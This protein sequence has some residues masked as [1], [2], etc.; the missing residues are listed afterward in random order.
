MNSLEITSL[1]SILFSHIYKAET[2]QNQFSSTKKF[3][4]ISY[5]SDGSLELKVG[6][7]LFC[8]KKGDVICFFHNTKTIVSAKAFHCHHTVCAMVDWQFTNDEQG[9]LLPIITPN[10]NNTANICL[11]IDDFVH[12]QMIYKTSKALG[13]SK[14]LE[15]LCAID[16]CNRNA[17]NINLPSTLLYT[18]KAK[19]YIQQNIHTCITQKSVADHLGVSPEYLCTVFKK[20]EGITIMHYVNKTKLENLK[21]LMD[22]TNLHLYEAAAIYGYTDPNYVSRL[23]KQIFGYNITHKPK[24]QPEIK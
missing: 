15:L 4:E 23:H 19:S 10:E 13:A 11:L 24:I 7:D 20:T 1:P 22:N 2:Y 3:L 21:T 6:N 5:V 17:Q 14:F 12:N 9:L 8:A 16:R 18:R